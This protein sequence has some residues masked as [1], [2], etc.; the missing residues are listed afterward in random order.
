[1]INALEWD[2]AF[3]GRRIAR[4]RGD[5]FRRDQTAALL[6]ACDADQIDC[7]YLLAD[8]ADTETVA[9]LQSLGAYFADVRMTFGRTIDGAEP[10]HAA[11]AAS[12]RPAVEGDVPSLARIAAVSHRD[13]RFHADRHFPSAL[14]DRLYEVWIENSCHGYA[15]AVFVAEDGHGRPCG[16]V[17]CHRD[18]SRR[19]HIGLFAVAAERQGGG[20]GTALLDASLAWFGSHGIFDMTVS[21]QLR[22]VRAVRFYGSGGLTLRSASFWFHFWPADRAGSRP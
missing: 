9:A 2:S 6:R 13:T 14:C 17:T 7:V 21:T 20:F 8:A 4:Y 15:D 22:N 3:F 12:I 16:Y 18:D 10:P 19:G 5:S 11:G 1:M